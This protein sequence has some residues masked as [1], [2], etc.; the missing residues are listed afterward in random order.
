MSRFIAAMDHSGGSTGGVLERYGEEFTEENKM[1]KVHQMRLRMVNSPLF[2]SDNIWAAILY[3][4][5]I[6]RGM[7]DVLESK[8]IKAICKIDSGCED[9]GM[10]KAFDLY[11]MID[12][13]LHNKCY[14]T[15]MR[16]IIKDQDDLN[17]IVLQQLAYAELIS[18]KGLMPIVEPEI[19]IDHPDKK[20]LEQ[21]LLHEL[22]EQL[23]VFNGKCI[24]KLTLPEVPN[25][26]R[27]LMEHSAVE[28][29][30]GLSGGYTTKQ[31]CRRLV[32]NNDMTAS[33]SR[34]LSEG[35]L[36]DMDE[37]TFN[38]TIGQ[39]IIMIKTAS[40]G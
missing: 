33:F 30:V 23:D 36:K 38:N 17:N 37:E 15:K 34:A 4:D 6:D 24:L 22:G 10:L 14:G 31:A 11:G 29:V 8:G 12:Y 35:L 19:P 5:T 7:V 21:A 20:Y 2:T 39:N 1:D 3:T 26:Y 32:V 28:K 13:T 27:P 18:S 25:L 40:N 9:N 16:S